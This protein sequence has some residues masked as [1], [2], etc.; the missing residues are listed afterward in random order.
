M[1]KTLKSVKGFTLIEVMVVII[2]IGI[3]AA[4]SVPVYNNYVNKG[5]AS[6]GQALVG[7]V[8]AA[9]KV[10][11]AQ[12]AKCLSVGNAGLGTGGG[13]AADPLGVVATQNIYFTAYDVQ[14]LQIANSCDYTVTTI[15]NGPPV[16]KVTLTQA[17]GAPGAQPQVTC[18]L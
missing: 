11:Y 7:A 13:D 5:K 6:E 17:N 10:Y 1:K 4:I 14:S 12:N 16:I 18:D 2:I 8:A 15:N 3:L 9:E